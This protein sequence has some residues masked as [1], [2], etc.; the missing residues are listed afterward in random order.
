MS[1]DEYER[2]VVERRLG[3]TWWKSQTAKGV[4]IEDLS[5]AEIVRTVEESIRRGR[6]ED[7]GTRNVKDLL[8]GLRL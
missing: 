4:G 5:E 8:R 2:R 7:P 6:M 3:A 1:R